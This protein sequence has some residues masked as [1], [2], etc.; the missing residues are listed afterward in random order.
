MRL[1]VYAHWIIIQR[2]STVYNFSNFSIIVLFYFI[3][4][5]KAALRWNRLLFVKIGFRNLIAYDQFSQK[6][7]YN[8]PGTLTILS[9]ELSSDLLW[10]IKVFP[11]NIGPVSDCFTVWWLFNLVIYHIVSIHKWWTHNRHQG[12][13][14]FFC[15]PLPF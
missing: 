1:A 14:H 9:H 8:V 10:F 15:S 3:Q 11:L 6:H 12:S 7:K 5:Q 4:T 13:Q 2:F